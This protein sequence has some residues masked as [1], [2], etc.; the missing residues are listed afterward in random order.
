MP[1]VVAEEGNRR[2]GGASEE[3]IKQCCID[4]QGW[5]RRKGSDADSKASSTDFQRVSKACG[6][7]LPRSLEI[8]LG[9]VNGGIFF[10]EKKALSA[11]EIM[12]TVMRLESTSG[13][14]KTMIPFAGDE[15][16]MLVVDTTSAEVYEWD[17]DD[18]IGS[19]GSKSLDDY[20]EDYRNQ[21]MTGRC[22]FDSDIGVI[23]GVGGSRK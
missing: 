16:G 23:E 19:M 10:L 22:E 17:E 18:G 4:I 8:L 20:L 14:K 9:E 12:E 13:W 11:E 3:E 6:L 7:E 21:L 5:F 2:K 1:V 15:G